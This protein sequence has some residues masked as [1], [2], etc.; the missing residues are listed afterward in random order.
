MP[1][2]FITVRII[3]TITNT[4]QSTSI[5]VTNIGD[6]IQ[7]FIFFYRLPQHLKRLEEL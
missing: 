2:R 5:I 3:P 4:P 7:D 1:G 6:M